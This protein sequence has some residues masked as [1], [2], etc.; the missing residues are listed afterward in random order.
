M[1]KY[2]FVCLLLLPLTSTST[3][4]S[5]QGSKK[6]IRQLEAQREAIIIDF[7][8]QRAEPNKEALTALTEAREDKIKIGLYTEEAKEAYLASHRKLYPVYSFM[9]RNGKI[10]SIKQFR[11]LADPNCD[12][13]KK[14]QAIQIALKKEQ[15]SIAHTRITQKRAE[16]EPKNVIAA[17]VA[18][19]NESY[20]ECRRALHVLDGALALSRLNL[21]Q[22]IRY[23]IKGS[24]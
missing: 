9:N 7:Y 16:Q 4:C 13:A 3:N 19:A 15:T 24:Q 23:G 12:A 6:I 5:S 20:A 21:E 14:I 17:R 2:V 8:M 10:K 22:G 1:K 11:A 18:S